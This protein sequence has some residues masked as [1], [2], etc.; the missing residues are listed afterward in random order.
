MEEFIQSYQLKVCF[1]LVKRKLNTCVSRKRQHL[2]QIMIAQNEDSKF[3][4]VIS[5]KYL[6]I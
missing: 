2:R 3:E 1:E 5:F 4:K 6:S